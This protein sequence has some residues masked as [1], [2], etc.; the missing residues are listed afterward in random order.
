MAEIPLELQSKL[1]RVLQEGEFER[2]GEERTRSVDVRIIAASNRH[3]EEE[4][5]AG[6]FRQDLYFRLN[7][8][9]IE[10][11]SLRERRDDIVLLANHFLT[12]A[13][14]RFGRHGFEL[15]ERQIEY[16]KQYDW[17]GNVRELCN[18][19][20]RAVILSKGQELELGRV[21]HQAH[22][23]S[24]APTDVGSGRKIVTAD[25]FKRIE[26]E[27]ILAALDEAG[28]RISGADGAAA[29]LCLAPSTLA[30]RMRKL[31]IAKPK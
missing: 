3:L 1:L 27:S 13:C 22:G 15:T 21:L 2:I 28:G 24:V 5:Q 6:R 4:I 26:R 17:L 31:G 11:P 14:Q 7:V 16:L 23:G 30:D 18:I 10:V 20:E 8:V 9:P 19:I 25:E 29:L 12:Q